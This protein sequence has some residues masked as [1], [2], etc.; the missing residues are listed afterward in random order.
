MFPNL[1]KFHKLSGTMKLMFLEAVFILAITKIAILILPLNRLTRSLSQI[2]DTGHSK[3]FSAEHDL[4]TAMA[5]K[6]AVAR[7]AAHT[8]WKS[9]CLVQSFT[10]QRMLKHRGIS[11]LLH[12]GVMKETNISKNNFQAHAWIQCGSIIITGEPGHE[13]FRIIS[14]F[15]W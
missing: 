3:R 11:G 15:S 2:K 6:T 10:A 4:Q 14:T 12:I 7:A 9:A 5:I 13:D 1:K 8:P